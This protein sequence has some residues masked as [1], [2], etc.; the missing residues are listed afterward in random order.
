MLFAVEWKGV[1]EAENSIR[2]REQGHQLSKSIANDG[3]KDKGDIDGLRLE[4][5]DFLDDGC[6]DCEA[7]TC[8]TEYM[9]VNV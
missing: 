8:S 4:V 7:D 3:N 5:V 9:S 2:S 6:E 1:E